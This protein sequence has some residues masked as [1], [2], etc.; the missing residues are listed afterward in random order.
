MWGLWGFLKPL[1]Y[2]KIWRPDSNILISMDVG[3]FIT[4]KGP[5]M[6]C[7]TPN[8]SGVGIF[9][10]NLMRLRN[11]SPRV[12]RFGAENFTALAQRITFE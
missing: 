6:E 11:L 1:K 3:N 10:S 8:S 5:C 7:E 9:Y 2:R 12:M 4:W